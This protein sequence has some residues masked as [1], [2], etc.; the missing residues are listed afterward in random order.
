MSEQLTRMLERVAEQ[1]PPSHLGTDALLQAG[2]GRVRRRRAVGLGSGVGALAVAGAIWLGL[3]DPLGAPEV[4]PASVT[5]EVD[6]PTTLTLVDRDGPDDVSS[7]VVT[8][9]VTGS[10]ASLVV[11]GEQETVAGTT[12]GFGAELYAGERAS[13]LVWRQPDA[14]EGAQVV[15]AAPGFGEIGAA[16]ADGGLW[17]AVFHE[18]AHVP[19]DLLFHG[20]GAVW[21]AGGE[22]AE[23]AVVAHGGVERTV[24]SLSGLGLG[25]VVTEGV[26]LVPQGD[27]VVGVDRSPWWRGGD[28]RDWV[29]ARLPQ[30]AAQA[31]LVTDAPG[32]HV[33]GGTVVDTV[34]LGDSTF[35]LAS[36][37]AAPGSGQVY[38]PDL[39]WSADGQ[40]WHDRDGEVVS[41]GGLAGVDL[42]GDGEQLRAA[43]A[44]V[45][46]EPLADLGDGLW[47]WQERDREAV[48]LVARTPDSH[49]TAE[50]QPI[51]RW[52]SMDS[53][54]V[55]I[56]PQF[57]AEESTVEVAGEELQAMLLD[58]G[59]EQLVGAASVNS[60]VTEGTVQ[61]LGG[62][63]IE[64]ALGEIGE[65]RVSAAEGVDHW[66]IWT[67][68]ATPGVVDGP[69]LTAI[70]LDDDT[71]SLVARLPGGDAD[72]VLVPRE[73]DMTVEQ[74]LGA[75]SE[76][77]GTRWWALT[78]QAPG[79][80]DL[81][82]VISGLDTDGD[83]ET[84]LP[85]DLLMPAS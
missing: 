47:A 20:G 50:L 26:D 28:E 75:T 74:P 15:P 21:T 9:T 70:Q 77:G 82:E 6:E 1:A 51:V 71:W 4:S 29:L 14:A 57:V 18:P 30:E 52:T 22:V 19:Q 63:S 23:T 65:V 72:P 62:P 66:A 76:S 24:F 58:L 3:G 35:A 40:E 69:G 5:W 41:S 81:R 37:P 73:A 39:Q 64:P 84:D 43:R 68:A 42:L 79:R 44:G 10:E 25:G 2:R 36:R 78:L 55:S 32:T 7:V 13:V 83:G 27:A 53:A 67:D 56:A 11:D 12:T 45:P 85:L 80:D 34:P 59:D 61:V 60:L 8:R 33:G 31:R 46:L 49:P 16:E 38:G 54:P 48:V 17:Y